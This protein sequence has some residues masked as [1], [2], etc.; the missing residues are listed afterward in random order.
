MEVAIDDLTIAAD[1]EEDVLII[2]QTLFKV[3]R[4]WGIR[5]NL[6]KSTFM[7]Q[8]VELLGFRVVYRRWW[9]NP[10]KLVAVQDFKVKTRRDL[11]AFLGQFNFIR[12]HVRYGSPAHQRLTG[13]IKEKIPWTWGDQE[14]ELLQEVR[15]AVANYI[16]IGSPL[17]KYEM[18]LITD[19]SKKGGGGGLWQWQPLDPDHPQ[20]FGPP[21]KAN[22]KGELVP[23]REHYRLVTLGHWGWKGNETRSRYSVWEQ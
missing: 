13:L 3:C 7:E 5:L 23:H 19:S 18:V 14:E 1:T 12:R 16:V 2:L 11:R 22:S 9:P 20:E 15:A 10:G 6:E 8:E 4:E 21:I 17:P